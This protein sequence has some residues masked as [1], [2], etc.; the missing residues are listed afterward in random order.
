MTPDNSL[1]YR[2]KSALRNH[3]VA[4]QA[5]ISSVYALRGLYG[6]TVGRIRSTEWRR[7]VAEHAT[8]GL[9]LGSGDFPLEGWF[10]TDGYPRVGRIAY[11]NVAGKFPFGDNAFAY[12]FNEHMIEHL[13]VEVALNMLRE[14]FRVLRHGGVIRIATPDL[15]K[16]FAL[17]REDVSPLERSYLQFATADTPHAAPG[18]PCFAIN[19]FVRAWGHQFIY[20]ADTLT[21]LLT[22][23][24]FTQVT[25]Q[26]NRAIATT[27][28]CAASRTIGA[29][30]RSRNITTSRRWCWKRRNPE[31]AAADMP[32]EETRLDIERLVRF[33]QIRIVPMDMRHR[34]E[35]DQFRGHAA[36]R[37]GNCWFR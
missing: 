19:Q 21:Q 8:P 20:D 22:V 25:R 34:I 32:G 37:G 7:Y 10:N 31:G 6:K 16:I 28:C 36:G 3:P 30:S 13:P 35:H 11:C 33:R 17:K 5:A 14:S 1:R 18:S 2:V 27:R 24:G 23:C 29:S 12:V 4:R 15:D 26:G 9:N